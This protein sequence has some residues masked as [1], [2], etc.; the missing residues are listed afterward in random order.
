MIYLLQLRAL[1]SA[2][3]ILVKLIRVYFLLTTVSVLSLSA[4]PASADTLKITSDPTGATVEIDGVKVG[5]TPYETKFPGGYFHKNPFGSR[6]EHPMKLRIAK[7]GFSSKEVEMTEGPIRYTG[8]SPL[9][10]A[11][12]GDCWL[13]KTNHFEFTL[14]PVSKSLTGAVTR[15]LPEAP[16]SKCGRN[17]TS[18]I[19]FNS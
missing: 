9:G 17:W 14:E 12:R 6:L 7:S 10:G 18:R 5:T 16:R 8:Y 19:S 4:K 11:Y 3:D 1:L 13:L 2:K 15:K